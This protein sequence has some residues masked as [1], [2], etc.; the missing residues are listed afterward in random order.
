MPRFAGLDLLNGL[1]NHDD[2]KKEQTLNLLKPYVKHEKVLIS[3]EGLVSNPFYPDIER[4]HRIARRIALFEDVHVIVT[5]R[6]Q[7]SIIDS[8]YR[9]F[10]QQGGSE[11]FDHFIDE[12]RGIFDFRYCNYYRLISEYKSILG[13]ES[14]SIFT[15]ER[16]LQNANEVLPRLLAVFG[17][18]KADLQMSN[19]GHGNVSMSNLSIRL[20]RFLNKFSSSSI[21]GRS[22]KGLFKST[23]LRM[24][25]QHR[26][27]PFILSKISKKKAFLSARDKEKVK[28]YYTSSNHNLDSEFDLSLKE[29]GYY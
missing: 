27:D 14:L 12:Q 6:N 18:T 10:I 2:Y 11:N 15:Q 3:F 19:L 16:L 17:K 28:S 5:I 23:S 20:M 26:I 4:S 21:N 24:L 25:M 1:M 9:Q 22:K 7:Y 8:L 13:N 29:L